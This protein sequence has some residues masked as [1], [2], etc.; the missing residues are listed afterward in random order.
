MQIHHISAECYPVAKVGGLADVVGA[1]PKYQREKGHD[2]KVFVPKY[3]TKFV[4]KNTFEVIFVGSIQFGGMYYPFSVHVDKS[5][6]LGFELHLISIPGLFDRPNVYSY[7]DDTQRFFAFQLAYLSWVKYSGIYLPD[8]VHCHDHHTGLIPFMMKY[9]YMFNFLRQTPSILTI[10]NAQYQGWMSKDLYHYFP[11]FNAADFGMLEWEGVINP[12][13]SAIKCSWRF[14]TVSS[15]YLEEIKYKANGLQDII[16]AESYKARGILNGIDVEVWNPAT[17]AYLPYH[18]NKKTV[19]KE[20]FKNKAHL[21]KTFGLDPKKPLFAFIGR[22]VPDKGADIIAEICYQAFAYYKDQLN[23]IV[24]GSGNDHV[25]NQLETV[26]QYYPDRFANFTGYDES[27]AHLI[28]ASADFLL[29]PSRVEPCGLNQMYALKYGTIPIVSRTGGLKDTILD[30]GDS[31]FGIC[32]DHTSVSDVMHAIYRAIKLYEDTKFKDKI[33]QFIMDI[34][35]SWE[36][37]ADE[38]VDMYRF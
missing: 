10:H 38:Y 27:L 32:H 30:I 7:S 33:V 37:V 28:Y 21:C 11:T 6:Q 16:R 9:T 13:A 34:D 24:L 29:M 2:V 3:D 12:L 20:K 23:I 36:K 15:S 8:V 26:K 4:Q 18:F 31:G 35:H 17:D 19:K 25:Q 5:N 1:L 14:S 22:L